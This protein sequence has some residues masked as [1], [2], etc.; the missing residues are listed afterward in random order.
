MIAIEVIDD[1]GLAEPLAA[2]IN[3]VYA[4]AEEGLWR[5]GTTRTSPADV[6][7]LISA[8]Q[9]AV[10]TVD[11]ELAGTIQVRA[12]SGDTGELGMLAAG[13]EHRSVGVGR[14]LV[15][16]AE[17]HAGDAGLGTMRLELLVP[18]TWRHPSKV[19]LDEWYRRIGYRVTSA[20]APAD[21]HPD[22]APLLATPCDFVVYEKPLM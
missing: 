21:A 2:L 16:F 15:A 20:A 7:G 10:A 5:D 17:R 6:A 14:D 3:E 11:G 18:R 8:R 4:I 9:I 12:V 22:L 1:S 19:F 13:F